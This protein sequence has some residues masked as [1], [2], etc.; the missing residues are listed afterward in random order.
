M[1][2]LITGSSRGLGLN[3]AKYYLDNGNSVIGISRSSSKLKKKKYIHFSADINNES[4]IK[5]IFIFIR[6]N[7]SKLDVLINNAGLASMN[8]TFLTPLDKASQIINTN[9]LGTFLLSREAGKLMKKKNFGRII[10]IST[11]GTQMKLEGEAIYTA[12]KAAVENLTVVMSREL[13]SYGITVNAVG[14]TPAMTDLIRFVP[15]NKIQ[16]IMK[17]LAFKRLTE[18]DDLTNVTDFFISKKSNYITGQLIYLGGG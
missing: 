2:F 9:F 10:N 13:S 11:V 5:K 14:P 8:H 1:V 15:K 4:E 17:N 7:F 18:T 6:N 3:L 16:N 12:S